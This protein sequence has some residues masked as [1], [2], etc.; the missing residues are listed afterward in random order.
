MKRVALALCVLV[1]H[2]HADGFVTTRTEPAREQL[3]LDKGSYEE[4][5]RVLARAAAA[6]PERDEALSLLASAAERARPLELREPELVLVARG[7]ARRTRTKPAR[8]ALF[9]LLTTPPREGFD[10]TALHQRIAATALAAA[11]DVADPPPGGVLQPGEIA[12]PIPGTLDKLLALAEEPRYEPAITE[13]LERHPP[14]GKPQ[15]VASPAALRI[16]AR[17]GDLR[18]AADIDATLARASNDEIRAAA[19]DAATALGVSRILPRAQALRDHPNPLVL[20]AALRAW[21]AFEPETALPQVEQRLVRPGAPLS[22]LALARYTHRAPILADVVKRLARVDAGPEAIRILASLPDDAGLQA[23]RAF[24]EHD[25]SVQIAIDALTGMPGSGATRV[26]AVLLADPRPLVRHEASL[27]L[28][29]RALDAG[30]D[31]HESRR[32]LAASQAQLGPVVRSWL[33]GQR[34][35]RAL[36]A[37]RLDATWRRGG[38]SIADTAACARALDVRAPACAYAFGRAMPAE[39]TETQ[40]EELRSLL[41]ASDP[42]VLG[43]LAQGLAES[44]WPGRRLA[45]EQLLG[46]TQDVALRRRLSALVQ[47]ELVTASEPDRVAAQMQRGQPAGLRPRPRL[48]RA[49]RDGRVRCGYARDELGMVMPLVL[50]DGAALLPAAHGDRLDVT[51]T[52][53]DPAV[54]K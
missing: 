54:A 37:T 26:L 27:G 39:S 51:F 11:A 13:A 7:L 42:S 22:V 25:G 40:R 38:H 52:R 53:C 41:A 36:A 24:A 4:R 16:G 5:A 45:L 49:E 34:S 32:A 44:A 10:G 30:P 6:A 9:A 28:L 35:R 1:G 23:L 46:R 15:Q 3:L 12:K 14:R 31:A 20:A 50:E 33:A 21:L 47:L 29:E 17:L 8:D 48:V 2:A 43:E 19:L 18:W